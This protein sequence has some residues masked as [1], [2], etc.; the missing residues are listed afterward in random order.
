LIRLRRNDSRGVA[1]NDNPLCGMIIGLR[2]MMICLRQN[3]GEF[4][5]CAQKFSIKIKINNSVKVFEDSKETF[6][7]KFL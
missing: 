5:R 3:E 6:F 2:R 1:A 7:K 4:P